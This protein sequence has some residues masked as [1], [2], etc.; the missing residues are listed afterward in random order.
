MNN[1]A[2]IPMTN[3]SAWQLSLL[4]LG[5]AT[6]AL[7]ALEVEGIVVRPT[8]PNAVFAFAAAGCAVA[9]ELTTVK[10]DRAFT[11]KGHRGAIVATVPGSPAWSPPN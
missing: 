2:Y 11:G 10:R 9:S 1:I 8:A 5:C 6:S 4:A 7:A 3:T